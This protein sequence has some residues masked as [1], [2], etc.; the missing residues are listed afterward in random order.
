MA[1]RKLPKFE[2]RH[3]TTESERMRVM[4]YLSY[5]GFHYRTVAK[6]VFGGGDPKYAVTN[7]DIS[8]VGKIAAEEKMSSRD[9]RNGIS[10]ESMRVLGELERSKS[11][12]A[13]AK[14]RA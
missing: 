10:R 12:S 6:R 5:G 1:K 2:A 14:I 9:W 8:R 3:F 7:A 13:A 11:L 4:I